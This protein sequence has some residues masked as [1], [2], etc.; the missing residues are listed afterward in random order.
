MS[1]DRRFAM[2]PVPYESIVKWCDRNGIDD[3]DARDFVEAVVR[4]VDAD[5]LR[6]AAAEAKK[7]A[8]P[9]KDPGGN[10][11]EGKP[12]RKAKR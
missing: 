1:S 4:E 9:P 2:G 6:K 3:P 11:P 10:I 12:K 7:Q 5:M 8:T